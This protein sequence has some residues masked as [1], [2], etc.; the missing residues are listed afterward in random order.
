MKMLLIVYFSFFS[1]VLIANDWTFTSLPKMLK[2]HVVE[3]VEAQMNLLEN[4]ESKVGGDEIWPLARIDVLT[5]A[6]LE[7]DLIF[8]DAKI[9]SYLE[10]RWD[11]KI[12]DGYKVYQPKI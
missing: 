10:L 1:N 4:N 12:K 11:K 9:K 6:Y 3:Q 7:Y 2:E 5:F 8:F